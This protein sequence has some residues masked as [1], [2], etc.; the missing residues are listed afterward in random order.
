[1][2]VVTSKVHVIFLTAEVRRVV[3]K[4]LMRSTFVVLFLRE[5][6][7]STYSIRSDPSK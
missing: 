7:L 3:L 1:M 6:F 2:F 4:V 5:A